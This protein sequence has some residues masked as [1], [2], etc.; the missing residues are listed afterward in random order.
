MQLNQ[1]LRVGLR[2]G[3]FLK[4]QSDSKLWPRLRIIDLEL[5]Q[6]KVVEHWPLPRAMVRHNHLA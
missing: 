5:D 1:T 4:I 3:Y 2:Y 6:V